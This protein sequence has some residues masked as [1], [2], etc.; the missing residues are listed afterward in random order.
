M[1]WD[2][3][4]VVWGLGRWNGPDGATKPVL[5]GGVACIRKHQATVW[6]PLEDTAR[7]LPMILFIE[8]KLNIKYSI[9]LPM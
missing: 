4:V 8:F 3:A 6:L 7:I 9:H 2:H 1:T 5:K